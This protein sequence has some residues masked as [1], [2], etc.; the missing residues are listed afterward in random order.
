MRLTEP[1]IELPN[2]HILPTWTEDYEGLCN[3]ADDWWNKMR[4]EL[5]KHPHPEELVLQEEITING[6]RSTILWKKLK[7]YPKRFGAVS[8]LI[9]A[10]ENAELVGLILAQKDGHFYAR[11]LDRH[12]AYLVQMRDFLI[13]DKR[14]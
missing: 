9:T 6:K 10:S 11:K 5:K 8:A 13:S 1:S 3:V 7:D 2:N 14:K 4:V 12:E